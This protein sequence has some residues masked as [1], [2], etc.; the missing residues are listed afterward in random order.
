M[1]LHPKPEVKIEAVEGNMVTSTTSYWSDPTHDMKI[2]PL[3]GK[4][5]YIS[6]EYP[7]GRTL[8]SVKT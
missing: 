5:L 2:A 8:T 7:N 3:I 4:D 6:M 1:P